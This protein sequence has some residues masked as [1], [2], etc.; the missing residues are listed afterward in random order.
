MPPCRV[1]IADI[2]AD[3]SHA[4]ASLLAPEADIELVGAAATLD[5]T[6]GLATSEQPDV[7]LFDTRVSHS[8]LDAT[9]QRLQRAAPGAAVVLMLIHHGDA[10]ASAEA[11]AAAWLMKDASRGE[12]LR[13]IRRRA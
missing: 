11:G 13:E 4:I 12:M 8:R 1:L 7:V 2:D 5:E 6:I 9:V 3:A 10:P